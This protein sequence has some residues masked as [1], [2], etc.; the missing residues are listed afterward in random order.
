MAHLGHGDLFPTIDWL[1]RRAQLLPNR[2]YTYDYREVLSDDENDLDVETREEAKV[3]LYY[4]DASIADF[5]FLEMQCG[6]TSYQVVMD[7]QLP[8]CIRHLVSEG[9]F[10]GPDDVTDPIVDWCPVN[11]TVEVTYHTRAGLMFMFER[12]V[13]ALGLKAIRRRRAASVIQA[14]WR[15][16]IANPSHPVC[17]KRVM[18]TEWEELQGE[19][20]D[21]KRARTD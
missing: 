4:E 13:F 8:E 17:R 9:L 1:L 11:A 10:E 19:L 15:D 20:V 2:Q 6:Y 3:T 7:A 12:I 18:V 21:C 14:R 5:H 16:A